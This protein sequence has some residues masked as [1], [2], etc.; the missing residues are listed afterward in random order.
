M[1]KRLFVMMLALVAAEVLTAEVLAA[2]LRAPFDFQSAQVLPQGIRNLRYKGVQVLGNEKY[3][4]AGDERLLADPFFQEITWRDVTDPEADELDT[5][6]LRGYLNSREYNLDEPVGRTTGTVSVAANVHIPVF[7]YGITDKLTAGV[8]VPII[9]YRYNV[10]TGFVA[11]EALNRL[12]A[13]LRAGGKGFELGEAERKL[14]NPINTKLAK[15]GYSPLKSEEGTKLGDINLVFKYQALKHSVITTTVQN[16]YVL[17]TGKEADVNKVLD[18]PGGDGQYDI[19]LALINDVNLIPLTT[20]TIT[21]G[22]VIQLPDTTA[23]RVPYRQNSKI[24]PYTDGAVKRNLGDIYF[25]QASSKVVPYMGVGIF[26]G[27]SLHYKQ[28]DRYRGSKYA[29]ERYSWLEADT[30]QN[31]QSVQLGLGYS[32]LEL[33]KAKRFPVPVELNATHSF[34]VRGKNVTKDPLTAVEL[35]MF[36]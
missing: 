23:K 36:F 27:Y 18:V 22:A 14:A 16:S 9:R 17:P 11:Y 6:L 10:D 26:V 30:I 24:T 28:E 31:M 34:L 32:T 3:N 25:V 21:P 13:D 19:G 7:A 12:A 5:G 35:V 8:A 33:F 29:S 2:D 20:I 15:F 4:S 1:G